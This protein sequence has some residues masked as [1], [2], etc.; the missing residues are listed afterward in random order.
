MKLFFSIS[1]FLSFLLLMQNCQTI[2]YDEEDCYYNNCNTI[3]PFETLLSVNYTK[4]DQNPHPLI[5]L[6]SGHYEE[7]NIIDTLSPDS[8]NLQVWV[9]LNHYYTV[10]AKY[11]VGNDSVIAIDGKYLEKKSYWECDSLCWKYDEGYIDVT[12]KQ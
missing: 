2:T 4:N 10:V 6:M 9:S 7:N 5:L 11:K 1:I 3:E 12:L 8:T